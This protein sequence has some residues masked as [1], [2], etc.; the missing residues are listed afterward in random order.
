[1]GF[2]Y[3]RDFCVSVFGNRFE[4]I[5]NTFMKKLSEKYEVHICIRIKDLE[6][7]LLILLNLHTE[8]LRNAFDKYLYG[9]KLFLVF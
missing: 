4:Q 6:L 3:N 8:K 5:R 7:F 9:N 1:M 2:M